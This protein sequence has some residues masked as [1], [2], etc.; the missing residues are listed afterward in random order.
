[1]RKQGFE[2]KQEL[3][4]EWANLVNLYLWL[5]QGNFLYVRVVFGW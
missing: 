1:M 5:P 4:A 3:G 2:L